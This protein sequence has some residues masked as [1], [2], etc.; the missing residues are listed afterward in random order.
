MTAMK[1]YLDRLVPV[2]KASDGEGQGGAPV[3]SITF[4]EAVP[5]ITHT[6]IEGKAEEIE[7]G[8]D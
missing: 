5:Q 1:I 8:G 2:K 6:V 7:D 3:I 4:P